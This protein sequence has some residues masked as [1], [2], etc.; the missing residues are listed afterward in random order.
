MGLIV[1]ELIGLILIIGNIAFALYYSLI[2]RYDA[3][4]FYL[5]MAVLIMVANIRQ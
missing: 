4:T 5:V 3:A 1:W 2:D